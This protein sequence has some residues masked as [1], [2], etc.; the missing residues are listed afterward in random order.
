MFQNS[1]HQTKVFL[2]GLGGGQQLFGNFR[3]KVERARGMEIIEQPELRL[4]KLAGVNV[5]QF[6]ILALK[7]G[8]LDV[9]KP[10]QT[11]TKSAFRSPRTAR[12]ASEFAGIA[13]EKTDDE[14]PF[15]EWPGLQDK[16]FAHTS[17]HNNGAASYENSR[18]SRLSFS[19]FPHSRK[20]HNGYRRAGECTRGRDTQ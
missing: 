8:H 16:G 14:V 10:L 2:V 18:L 15:L 3:Y 6:A 13:R 5:N 1:R 11:G 19:D 17:G 9:R 12:N 20:A 7:V 4:Q